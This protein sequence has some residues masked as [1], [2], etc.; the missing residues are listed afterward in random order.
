MADLLDRLLPVLVFLIALTLIAD[1]AHRSGV[2]EAAAAWAAR[3]AGGS[4]LRL[5]LLMVALA[6]LC[7]IVLSLDTT[8]IVLTPVV[9]EV[10]RR[11]GLPVLPS[12]ITTV[13][14]ELN[15]SSR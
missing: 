8:A 15:A 4:A 9:I 2:F 14:P 5:W 3:V 12:A 13:C 6:T 1:V 7:T 11:A 10:A